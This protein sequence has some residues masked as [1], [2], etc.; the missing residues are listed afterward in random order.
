MAYF[1]GA[2]FWHRT[3]SQKKDRQAHAHLVDAL[4]SKTPGAAGEVLC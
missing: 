1:K 4:A 2:E 3:G